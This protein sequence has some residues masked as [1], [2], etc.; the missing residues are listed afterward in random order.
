MI[1]LSPDK[2][3]HVPCSLID[4][5]DL[6]TFTGTVTSGQL[7]DNAIFN[8]EISNKVYCHV[9][10]PIKLLREENYVYTSYVEVARAKSDL[11]TILSNT[12]ISWKTQF[13]VVDKTGVD[14]PGIK[15]QV[16]SLQNFL[17]PRLTLL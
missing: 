2:N 4:K 15:S 11:F 6:D 7:S 8:F 1:V 9:V 13:R 5:Q 14:E 10:V 17:A 16:A 12:K 3:F